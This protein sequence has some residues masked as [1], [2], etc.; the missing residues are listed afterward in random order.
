MT[1][2]SAAFT[3]A[4]VLKRAL[5]VE[6]HS[7]QDDDS[8]LPVT[9][10]EHI[11][12]GDLF[13]YPCFQWDW[14]KVPQS[15]RDHHQYTINI[16]SDWTDDYEKLFSGGADSW[17]EHKVIRFLTYYDFTP[18]LLLNPAFEELA[19][20]FPRNVPMS[21]KEPSMPSP[22]TLMMRYLFTPYLQKY[23]KKVR[24]EF[25]RFRNEI[26][27]HCIDS[28]YYG[29]H[30]RLRSTL[31]RDNMSYF[32]CLSGLS[33]FT[34]QR[35]YF[36]ASDSDNST[37]KVVPHIPKESRLL[38]LN[39]TRER[40]T[41]E[42]IQTALLEIYILSS[43]SMLFGFNYSSYAVLAGILKGGLLYSNTCSTPQSAAPSNVCDRPHM[44]R[45]G[46]G[47]SFSHI[48]DNA[49]DQRHRVGCVVRDSYSQEVLD[50]HD[51]IKKRKKSNDT[52]DEEDDA[53][54]PVRACI[55]YVLTD[56]SQL[57]DFVE[58][59]L[60]S[61]AKNMFIP[62]GQLYPVVVFTHDISKTK[63][64]S[65]L[66]RAYS[67]LLTI[68]DLGPLIPPQS[69]TQIQTQSFSKRKIPLKRQKHSSK[70]V[71]KY[72][73]SSH[74]N[75]FYIGL[76]FN[77]TALKGYDYIMRLDST[78][79]ISSPVLLNPFRHMLNNGLNYAH[80]GV[81]SASVASVNGL[82]QFVKA[83]VRK[84]S[85]RPINLHE[86]LLPN[87]HIQAMQYSTHLEIVRK[88]FFLHSPY[89]DFFKAIDRDLGLYTHG[90][91]EGAIK[92]LGL[93]IF[94]NPVSIR[95]FS[96]I[97]KVSNVIGK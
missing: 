34:G 79:S 81:V 6:W 41:L 15:I 30:L 44:I 93:A 71:V 37:K 50:K 53:P 82:E 42:G 67:K 80:S 2:I 90:W 95:D 38:S 3:L 74:M 11:S 13:F 25:N 7:F 18:A 20:G 63:I 62:L 59:S 76:L 85:V 87:G 5:V 84:N 4:R 43:S 97:V 47:E 17:S 24:T 73:I 45:D 58:T 72:T 29:L 1:G 22:S 36:V 23:T 26:R 28:T 89:Y 56:T 70:G 94:A 27:M 49:Y 55:V 40:D 31:A 88:E 69:P 32:P 91:T 48:A 54:L 65:L 92:H 46:V 77:H 14:A 61:L 75:R 57:K 51:S 16:D 68:E 8:G 83:Y 12:L 78:T 33:A 96:S 64:N 9:R 19:A 60:P 86:F 35:C 10:V 52:S 21:A 66:H 39:L